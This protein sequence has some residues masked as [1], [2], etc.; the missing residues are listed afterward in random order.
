MEWIILW[1]ARLARVAYDSSQWSHSN[2]SS[3]WVSIWALSIPLLRKAFGHWAQGNGVWPECFLLCT[4]RSS[5]LA[6]FLS[7][8]SHAKESLLL[9][10]LQWFL[11][12]PRLLNFLRQWSHSNGASP[13]CFR[14]W[15]TRSDCRKNLALQMSQTWVFVLSIEVSEWAVSCFLSSFLL[16]N[17]FSH[18][19]Q[20]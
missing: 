8:W 2:L 18:L 15:M 11:I 20:A 10:V 4:I 12:S 19:S 6:Y 3:E 14:L 1:R 7:H 13:E 16:R 5:F 17:D 9:W